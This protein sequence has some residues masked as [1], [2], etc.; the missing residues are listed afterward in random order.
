MYASRER[1]LTKCANTE[2]QIGK[3]R[4]PKSMHARPKVDRSKY[5]RFH[6]GHRHNTEECIHLK[7][8]IEILIREGHLKQYA[9]KQE[10]PQ[11]AKT[12]AE[13]KPIK[14]TSALQVAM[15]V[16]RPKD[17]YIHDWASTQMFF[18]LHNPWEAFLSIMVISGGGF[19]KLTVGSVK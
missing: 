9:K 13:E 6:K 4:F 8:T 3:V 5:C 14:D 15:S 2:F 12:V 17:L 1:I 7:D 10:T 18:S 16:T 11:E 19:S